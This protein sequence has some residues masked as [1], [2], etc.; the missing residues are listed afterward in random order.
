MYAVMVN[1]KHGLVEIDQYESLL[2]A[3]NIADVYKFRHPESDYLVVNADN[4][5]VEYQT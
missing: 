5:D 4:G 3:C 1:A 2:M